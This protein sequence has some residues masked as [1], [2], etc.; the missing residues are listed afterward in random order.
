MSRE[1]KFRVWDEK[2]NCW[3]TGRQEFYPNENI[4]KQGRVFQQYTGF[5]DLNGKE[6]YEGDILSACDEYGG[7]IIGEV[8]F[9]KGCWIFGKDFGYEKTKVHSYAYVY[10][11]EGKCLVI[12]NVFETPELLKNE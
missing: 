12:G 1:L 5:K 4:V 9:E 6:I 10:S 11:W 2:L 3:E 8:I 7:E